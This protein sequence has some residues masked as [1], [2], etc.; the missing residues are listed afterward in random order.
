[1]KKSKQT[2]L[3]QEIIKGLEESL[4]WAKAYRLGRLH[5]WELTDA[6]VRNHGGSKTIR[7]RLK[8]ALLS[9]KEVE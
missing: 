6:I 1:M 3:G 8:K 4:V 9:E 7:A 2:P 5:A